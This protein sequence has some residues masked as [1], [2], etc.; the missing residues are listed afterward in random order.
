[1][2]GDVRSNVQM[3]FLIDE[4]CLNFR[5]FSTND[6][7]FNVRFLKLQELL[8]AVPKRFIVASEVDKESWKALLD[9]DLLKERIHSSLKYILVGVKTC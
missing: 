4:S 6:Y 1:M 9:L 5:F 2:K 8:K 3:A 7:L